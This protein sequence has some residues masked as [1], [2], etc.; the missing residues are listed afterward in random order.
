MTDESKKLY[1]GTLGIFVG[2]V[3]LI[4]FLN[5]NAIYSNIKKYN[6]NEDSQF[7]IVY[8]DKYYGDYTM[9]E[10][11]TNTMYIK[12]DGKYTQILDGNGKPLSYDVW[13]AANQ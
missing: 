10:K 12:S 2:L 8:Y 3:L 9:R 11:T 13:A 1:L 6:E 7:E 4:E 5:K